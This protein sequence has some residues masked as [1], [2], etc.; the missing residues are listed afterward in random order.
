MS[1]VE[2]FE[3]RISTAKKKR[4]RLSQKRAEKVALLKNA[5]SKLDKLQEKAESQGFSL[6]DLEE[7]IKNKED[8]LEVKVSKF[9]ADLVTA[10]EALEK[11]ED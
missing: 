7:K 8:E 11:Y 5:Q 2:D 9:E 3:K 4:E 1:K 6:E 10:E